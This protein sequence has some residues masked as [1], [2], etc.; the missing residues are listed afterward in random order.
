MVSRRIRS[1]HAKMVCELS[2]HLDPDIDN[3]KPWKVF[4]A[5]LD[6]SPAESVRCKDI[7]DVFQTLMNKGDIDYGS[8]D[9][10]KKSLRKSNATACKIIDKYVNLIKRDKNQKKDTLSDCT[11]NDES[12][13]GDDADCSNTEDSTDD[14]SEEEEEI[15]PKGKR[16]ISPSQQGSFLY[17]VLLQFFITST[18]KL[19]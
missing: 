11:D 19:T 13:I 18:Y 5:Q 16:K 7:F 3:G 15:T 1:L 17:H 10:V 9:K 12:D 8:Y 2:H 6:F 4:K 14:N